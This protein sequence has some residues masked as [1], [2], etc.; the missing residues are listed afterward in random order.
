MR[1]WAI[2]FL[3]LPITSVQDRRVIFK[4][5]SQDGAREDFSKNLRASLSL[6]IKYPYN[7]PNFGRIHLAGQYL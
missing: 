1:Y 5:L 7:E 4:G 6:F 2:R 3:I